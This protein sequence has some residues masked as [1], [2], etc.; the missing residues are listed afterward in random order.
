MLNI[1]LK[2]TIENSNFKNIVTRL[3]FGEPKL[4]QIWLNLHIIELAST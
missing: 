1:Y 3:V 2:V 4:T